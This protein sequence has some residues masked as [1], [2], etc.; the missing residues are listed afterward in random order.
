MRM[1]SQ[2]GAAFGFAEFSRPFCARSTL[3]PLYLFE[4]ATQKLAP[5][6]AVVRESAL[7]S[8]HENPFG[9]YHSRAD[10]SGPPFKTAVANLSC[11]HRT[12]R[13]TE[14]RLSPFTRRLDRRQKGI[15]QI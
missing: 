7:G 4:L 10:Q 8:A 2:I 3:G 9:L 1:P 14:C 5:R 6:P 15:Y 11:R 12:W 13:G